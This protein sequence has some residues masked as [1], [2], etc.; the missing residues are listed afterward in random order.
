MRVR[1]ASVRLTTEK[2]APQEVGAPAPD[3]RRQEKETLGHG[4]QVACRVS[5]NALPS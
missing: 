3:P 4:G 1:V 5:N 2:G